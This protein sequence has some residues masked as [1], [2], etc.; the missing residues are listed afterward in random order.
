MLLQADSPDRAAGILPIEEHTVYST[1]DAG[2][3]AG[4]PS[5]GGTLLEMGRIPIVQLE[6]AG[7]STAV[8]QGSTSSSEVRPDILHLRCIL[9]LWETFVASLFMGSLTSDSNS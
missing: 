7:P 5:P 6:A 4:S 9:L 3:G 1:G 2:W 8:Q